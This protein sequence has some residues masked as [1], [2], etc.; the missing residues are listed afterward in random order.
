MITL[1]TDCVDCRSLGE[2]RFFAREAV[3]FDHVDAAARRPNCASFFN[4][5]RPLKSL[6]LR[7]E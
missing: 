6:E 5:C 4:F 7:I 1:L 2:L 3:D